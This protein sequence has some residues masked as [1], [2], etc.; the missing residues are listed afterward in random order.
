MIARKVENISKNDFQIIV[1]VLLVL[2]KRK[3]SA[4]LGKFTSRVVIHLY[5][6]EKVTV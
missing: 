6:A 3:K 2:D 1:N 4:L 5:F